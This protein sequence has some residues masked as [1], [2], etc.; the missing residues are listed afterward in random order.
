MSLAR[1]STACPPITECPEPPKSLCG[2]EGGPGCTSKDQ[3][4]PNQDCV[5]GQCVNIPPGDL[6]N[7]TYLEYRIGDMSPSNGTADIIVPSPSNGLVMAQLA[8][9]GTCGDSNKSFS[10]S[11]LRARFVYETNVVLTNLKLIKDLD[12]NGVES[13]GDITVATV[14]A[15]DDKY[16]EFAIDEAQRVLATGADHHFLIVADAVYAVASVPAETTFL[17]NIEGKASFIANDANGN[18]TNILDQSIDF[19]EFMFEPSSGAFIFTKGPKEPAEP[20]A[21]DLNENAIPIMHIRAKSLDGDNQIRSIEVERTGSSIGF[22]EGIESVSIWEDTNVDG[23]GDSLLVTS[24]T[25]TELV[26]SYLFDGIN[27]NPSFQFADKQERYYVVMVSFN[28]KADTTAQ[29]QIPRLGVKLVNNKTIIELPIQSRSY[30]CSQPYC[31][32]KKTP[33]CTCSVVADGNEPATP[34][35]GIIL[36]FAA[37]GLAGFG[38][39]SRRRDHSV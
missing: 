24:G 35:S 13:G 8:V 3:C 5:D 33:E 14:S 32:E 15:L 17:A 21:K 20:A 9:K 25:L 29:L 23:I 36:L 19:A 10:L 34:W 6:C 2:G 7:N 18:M 27:N 16:A 4:G 31:Y 12:N 26:E 11:M 1:F 38:L 37:L 28:L 22:G 39:R 30:Q